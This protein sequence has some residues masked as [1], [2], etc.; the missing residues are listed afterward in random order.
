MAVLDSFTVVDFI[1]V[2]IMPM[3]Y[4]ITIDRKFSSFIISIILFLTNIY[5]C[6]VFLKLPISLFLKNNKINQFCEVCWCQ[7][8][9]I[10]HDHKQKSHINGYNL[11]CSII[12]CKFLSLRCIFNP[13]LFCFH[14][15]IFHSHVYLP[16]SLAV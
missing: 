15:N 10:G 5:A 7:K 6:F 16:F 4:R 12:S 2:K 14:F 3:L 11:H 1:K 13:H 8:F 9:K